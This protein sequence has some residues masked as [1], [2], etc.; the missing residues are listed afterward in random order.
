MDGSPRGTSPKKSYGDR[1]EVH[2]R[3]DLAEH[4]KSTLQSPD[5]KYFVDPAADGRMVFFN[6]KTGTTVVFN[7]HQL[8]DG[9]GHV[10]TV[11][12]EKVSEVGGTFNRELGLTTER[13]GQAPEIKSAADGKWSLPADVYHK[14]TVRSADFVADKPPIQPGT[15][16]PDEIRHANKLDVAEGAREISKLAKA[17]RLGAN[18]TGAGVVIG[19]ASLVLM[20]KA[21]AAQRDFAG[22]LKEA[23]ILDQDAYKSYVK[24]NHDTQ[25]ML[26]GDLALSTAD[27]TGLSIVVTAAAEGKARTDF[28]EWAD[29]HAPN[30]SEEHFQT[31]SMSAFSGSSARADMVWE[32]RDNL[33]S[34]TEGQPLE[35]QRT[36]ELN[37]LY[38]DARSI[39]YSHRAGYIYSGNYGE[40]V[41]KA[42]EM[43]IEFEKSSTNPSKSISNMREAIKTELMGEMDAR[44][45]DPKTA[46]RMLD[47]VPVEDR[48]EY[49]RRL[50]G[51]DPNPE[52]FKKDHPEMAA[53]VKEYDDS[54]LGA[55]WLLDND[56]PLKKS[57]DLI[58]DYIKER[59][60]PAQAAPAEPA[61]NPDVNTETKVD[62]GFLPPNVEMLKHRLGGELPADMLPKIPTGNAALAVSDD[63]Q[64]RAS[65]QD[66][67]NEAYTEAS[68]LIERINDPHTDMDPVEY[69]QGHAYLT[70]VN[71]PPAAIN[72]L[73]SQYPDGMQKLRNEELDQL[74]QKAGQEVAELD[75]KEWLR[76][77]QNMDP[78]QNPMAGSDPNAPSQQN[79]RIG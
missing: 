56:D 58:D 41:Q 3:A 11:M 48:L 64:W 52:Q 69:N 30:M 32:A 34:S 42:Q 53:Y 75:R 76:Q 25:R 74:D 45:T 63:E 4:V 35:M 1:F 14:P 79:T 40:T 61:I 22:D 72:L 23:G 59:T 55:N 49:A 20:N 27:P 70:D 36:I 17:G 9:D 31:L 29:K 7:P 77:Q 37:N 62:V 21:H 28:R 50:A 73:E 39:H 6:E 47:L 38:N 33:P 8:A 19:G 5:T 46:D 10:G 26:Y 65:T 51:S 43:G 78:Y 67:T 57:P 54:L 24:L 16:L 13:L 12:R 71:T 60:V 44:L 2:S 18:I 15:K 68:Q 66:G